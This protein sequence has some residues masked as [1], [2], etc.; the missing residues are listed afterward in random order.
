MTELARSLLVFL[1]SQPST[2]STQPRRPNALSTHHL[3]TAVL[4]PVFHCLHP[5]H[6]IS[7]LFLLSALFPTTD[8]CPSSRTPDASTQLRGRAHVDRNKQTRGGPATIL[9]TSPL[10]KQRHTSASLAHQDLD[11]RS[12][13]KRSTPVSL[14][15]RLPLRPR[16]PLR[17]TGARSEGI[18]SR[19]SRQT[20]QSLT[21]IYAAAQLN[22]ID[23]SPC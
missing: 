6:C 5:W 1:P 3:L 20:G 17:R 2:P 10:P 18:S 16:P 12:F 22:F 15:L 8:H 11:H 14:S 13:I 7:T 4:Y 19:R 23:N 21:V 9:K